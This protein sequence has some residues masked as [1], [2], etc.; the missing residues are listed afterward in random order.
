MSPP[1]STVPLEHETLGRIFAVGNGRCVG[2][3]CCAIQGACQMGYYISERCDF[4][5]E[6][7]AE[8]DQWPST[9][10]RRVEKVL[11]KVED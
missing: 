4:E 2:R 3:P 5:N 11:G 10:D 6:G 1:Q 7:Y 9:Q 8:T